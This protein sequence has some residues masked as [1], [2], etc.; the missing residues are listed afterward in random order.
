M[1]TID[2]ARKQT[3]PQSPAIAH[4]PP[5]AKGYPPRAGSPGGPLAGMPYLAKDLFDV[6]GWPTEASSRFLGRER[7]LPDRPAELIHALAE[8]GATCIGKTHLNEFAYGLSGENPHFGDCPHPFAHGRLSGGS[9][10]GSAYAVAAGWVP[11]ATGTDTGGSIRVP[12][13]FCNVWGIRYKP[14]FLVKGCFPLAPSFDTVGFLAD[15]SQTLARVHGAVAP[16]SLG[17]NPPECIGLFDPR[18]CRQADMAAHYEAAFSRRGIPLDAALSREMGQWMESLPS[19]FNILQSGQA[20]EVHAGWLD[21]C[22]D[23]YDPAVWERIARART[24]TKDQKKRATEIRDRFVDWMHIQL[25][26]NRALILPAVPTVSPRVE[27]LEPAFRERLL[28]LTSPASMAGLPVL[29]EPVPIPGEPLS[30]GLQYV[31]ASLQDLSALL[32]AVTGP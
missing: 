32:T 1:I 6:P 31:V 17:G 22:K 26:G 3:E 23:A 5:D 14:G 16:D 2:Q 30:L 4:L 27:A 18:W 8:A 28:A 29:T 11:F 13:A 12:A 10:S 20:M 25:Q 24:W 7:G 15:S 21:R 9:S 19:A